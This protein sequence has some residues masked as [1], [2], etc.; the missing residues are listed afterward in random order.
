MNYED[1]KITNEQIIE[2]SKN[3]YSNTIIPQVNDYANRNIKE[4]FDFY[5]Q[6]DANKKYK[7]FVLCYGKK[8]GG[9]DIEG[10]KY[11]K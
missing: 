5:I 1:L 7:L 4:Y 6:L 9:I 11:G 3:L 2:L 8:Y 10:L